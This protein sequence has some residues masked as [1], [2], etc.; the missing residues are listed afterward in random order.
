MNP[1]VIAIDGGGSKTDVVAVETTGEVIARRTGPG[2]PPHTIGIAESVRVVDS[3]AAAV[4]SETGS[5]P[6]AHAGVFLSGLDLPSETETYASALAATVVLGSAQ[7]IDLRN[8]I[9]AVLRAGT[10]AR[11]AAAVVCGTGINA[12]G[13]RADGTEVR[14]AALGEISGDWG[15][16]WHLGREA[17]W[18]AARAAD[19]RGPSTTLQKSVPA[20]FDLDE[21]GAVT[22]AFHLKSFDMSEMSRLSPV[23][24]DA[25]AAGDEVALSIIDRQADEIVLLAVVALQRLDLLTSPVPIVLGGGVIAG[26]TQLVDRVAALL[27]KRAP[28]ATLILPAARP[29]V[30]AVCLALEH[31]GASP[32]AIARA[33][34]EVS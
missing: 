28:A 24:F 22:E 30:G 21:V 3:L 23:V 19:G 26:Q 18:H 4:L 15:G 31:I 14:F 29:I 17:L 5:R 12:I 16:G 7:S 9:Y 13:V 6:I 20:A 33:R 34:T 27:R 32:E 1:F 25:A 10:D 11:D 8:D 2:S